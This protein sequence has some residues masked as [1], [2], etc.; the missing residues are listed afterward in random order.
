MTREE[1]GAVVF[2]IGYGVMFLMAVKVF[3]LR[4]VLW[5]LGLV[6]FL[7]VAVA[8]KTLG[9]VTGGRRY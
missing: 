7:A 4:R 8:F 9:A 1:L 3:G 6:V 5:A 2:V